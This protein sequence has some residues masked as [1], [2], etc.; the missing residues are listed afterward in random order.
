[1]AE[2]HFYVQMVL[3]PEL[4]Y[5]CAMAYAEL[6]EAKRHWRNLKTLNDAESEQPHTRSHF[7]MQQGNTPPGTSADMCLFIPWLICKNLHSLV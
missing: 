3:P 1:M 7:T 4:S 6:M 2:T 5:H